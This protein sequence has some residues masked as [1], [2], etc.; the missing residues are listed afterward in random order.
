MP[1][2][3]TLVV[4]ST[5]PAVALPRSFCVPA[6][7]DT[8]QDST[9]KYHTVRCST[10]QYLRKVLHAVGEH[11]GGEEH[12]PRSGVPIDLKVDLRVLGVLVG[13]ADGVHGVPSEV[14]PP[15]VAG[16][17]RMSREKSPFMKWPR[18]LH[19]CRERRSG[20]KRGNRGS[21][22]VRVRIM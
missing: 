12:G 17:M 4:S 19:A 3:K 14:D 5:V 18:G 7:Y 1:L 20:E 16:G 22:H 21:S 2:A 13:G 8:A 9:V 6:D 10:A 15:A 11:V